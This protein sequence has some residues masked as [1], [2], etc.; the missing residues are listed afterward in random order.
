M[1]KVLNILVSARATGRR[2]SAQRRFPQ[3]AVLLAT[4]LAVFLIANALET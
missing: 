4:P 1:G 2:E 3:I